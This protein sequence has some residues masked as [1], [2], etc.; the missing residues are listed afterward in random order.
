MILERLLEPDCMEMPLCRCGAQMRLTKGAAVKPTHET[1]IRAFNCLVCG[2]ELKL[3]VWS[4]TD[5]A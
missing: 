3:T 4:R 2:H 5:A 1:E